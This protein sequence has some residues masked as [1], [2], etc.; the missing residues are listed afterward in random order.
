MYYLFSSMSEGA[1][2]YSVV[3][4]TL[5]PFLVCTHGHHD[6]MEPELYFPLPLFKTVSR[7]D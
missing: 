5:Y 7:R 3:L 2:N 4:H 1:R 6:R